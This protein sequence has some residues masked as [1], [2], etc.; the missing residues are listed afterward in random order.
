MRKPTKIQILNL[1]Y[2]IRWVDTAI[3]T[4][5]DSQG[6]CDFSEQLIVICKDN[7]NQIIRE[8]FIHEIFHALFNAMDLMEPEKIDHEQLV[9]RTATGFCTVYNQN[10]K[11]FKWWEGLK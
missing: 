9:T 8:V 1:T 4:G 6:W 11:V 2:S 3:E 7:S 5:S 10:K